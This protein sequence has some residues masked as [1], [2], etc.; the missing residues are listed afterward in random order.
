MMTAAPRGFGLDVGCAL[1]ALSAP[2]LE[3]QRN[4]SAAF[5]RASYDPRECDSQECDGLRGC[6]GLQGGDGLRGC[7][8]RT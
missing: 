5:L 7:D 4:W 2:P 6:D 3:V 1:D 8:G